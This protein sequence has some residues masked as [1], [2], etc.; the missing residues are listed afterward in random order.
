MLAIQIRAIR[1]VNNI[2]TYE[3]ILRISIF[4]FDIFEGPPDWMREFGL[5]SIYFVSKAVL[6]TCYW[7]GKLF[8]G[9]DTKYEEYTPTSINL[10]IK[11]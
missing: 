7:I 5:K 8:L 1:H 11:G 10:W 6:F 9:M 2:H 3:G 4:N